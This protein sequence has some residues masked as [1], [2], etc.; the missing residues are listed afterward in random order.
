MGRMSAILLMSAIASV[1]AISAASAQVP[2]PA[3]AA[4]QRSYPRRPDRPASPVMPEAPADPT[5]AMPV[6]EPDPADD[7]QTG[8]SEPGQQQDAVAD[9]VPDAGRQGEEEDTDLGVP[10]GNLP[11]INPAPIEPFPPEDD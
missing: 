3:P 7:L 11:L 1:G 4:E 8:P 6:G 9:A 10:V 2:V 5:Q